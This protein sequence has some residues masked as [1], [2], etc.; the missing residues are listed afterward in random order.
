M[1]ISMIHDLYAILFLA[2][3][4][5]TCGILELE[6]ILGHLIKF[7][8]SGKSLGLNRYKAIWSISL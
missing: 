6:N 7:L 5:K 4:S 2:L 1:Y 3:E 8:Y